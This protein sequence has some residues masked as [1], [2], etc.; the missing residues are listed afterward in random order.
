MKINPADV[1]DSEAR[2]LLIRG[3][4]KKVSDP[5]IIH[6]YFKFTRKPLVIAHAPACLA[7]VDQ[8][9]M[10]RTNILERIL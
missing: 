3:S 10:F 8:E 5:S 1:S 2:Y 7:Y 9:V 6:G 4:D